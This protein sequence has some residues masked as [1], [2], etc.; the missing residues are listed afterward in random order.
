[1]RPVCR[2]RIVVAVLLVVSSTTIA[3]DGSAAGAV[4]PAPTLQAREGGPEIR[5]RLER[6]CRSAGARRP[7][8][9][10]GAASAS[11][12]RLPRLRGNPGEEVVVDTEF[13]AARVVARAQPS[14][15]GRTVRVDLTRLDD[16][17]WVFAMPSEQARLRIATTYADGTVTV[18]SV[19]LR[20]SR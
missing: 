17:R 4:L 7:V 11:A 16:R 20:P 6:L 12:R 18:A 14:V 3:F 19:A 10:C 15:S 8:P 5:M 13:S 9:R 2:V 1:M